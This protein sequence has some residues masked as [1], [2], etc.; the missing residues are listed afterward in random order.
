MAEC[1][2]LEVQRYSALSQLPPSYHAL[3]EQAGRRCVFYTEPW[4]RNFE[5]TVV[6]PGDVPCVCRFIYWL[7]SGIRGWLLMLSGPLRVCSQKLTELAAGGVEGVL[8]LFGDF[9]P[10]ERAAFVVDESQ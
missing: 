7:V 10:D 3:F 4:F 8:L 6:R 2:V 1:A 9:G 5:D